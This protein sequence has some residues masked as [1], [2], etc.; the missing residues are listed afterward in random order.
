MYV[1]PPA[2]PTGYCLLDPL[3]CAGDTVFPVLHITY[4]RTNSSLFHYRNQWESS[5]KAINLSSVQKGS[6]RKAASDAGLTAGFLERRRIKKK[7]KERVRV[8]LKRVNPGGRRNSKAAVLCASFWT[9]RAFRRGFESR[10][11][12]HRTLIINVF[13]FFL[14]SHL[15]HVL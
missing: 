10:G 7:E 9:M 6:Q 13:L 15:E 11:K 8:E 1:P 2:F 4:T 14:L 12:I 3:R 5:Q